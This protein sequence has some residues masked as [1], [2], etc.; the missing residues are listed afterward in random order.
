LVYEISTAAENDFELVGY[1][2]NMVDD[3]RRIFNDMAVYFYEGYFQEYVFY[4]N[5]N[6]PH[7]VVLGVAYFDKSDI[8]PVMFRINGIDVQHQLDYSD[9]FFGE[10]AIGF[11]AHI[12]VVFPAH[13]ETI[14][15]VYD[16]SY[17]GNIDNTFIFKGSPR[18]TAT[19]GNHW[20]D[21][22]R[23]YFEIEENWI[24][25]IFF[26]RRTES[27]VSM[28]E[29][30]GTLSNDLFTIQKTDGNTWEIEFTRQFVDA[31]RSNLAFDIEYGLWGQIGGGYKV[32]WRNHRG[33]VFNSE[34]SIT[35]YQYLFLTNRQLQVVRNAYYA[36][37]GY[38][39]KNVA[40]ARMYN[41]DRFNFAPS[42]G[43]INY[44]ENPNFTEDMLTE[45]DRANIAII[46]ALEA[47]A[48]DPV[49]AYTS[50]FPETESSV[51][52]PTEAV[53]AALF[54]IVAGLPPEGA[55]YFTVRDNNPDLLFNLIIVLCTGIVVVCVTIVLLAARKKRK[56]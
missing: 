6:V 51:A 48:P 26:N 32:F 55:T 44:R 1:H 39:F 18:F 28:L 50:A 30:R 47:L 9:K 22:D 35:P 42:F 38:I 41:F 49:G 4:N 8:P 46:Q 17:I 11:F 21:R 56:G 36:R 10:N 54:E 37:H 27:L 52:A 3:N 20:I 31:H 40:L 7:K 34:D 29:K 43:S 12:E 23:H 14:I 53:A 33:I 24:N 5:G 16:F 19:I 2:V 15:R 25:D 13:E 45:T